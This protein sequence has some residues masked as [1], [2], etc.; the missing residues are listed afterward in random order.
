[1]VPLYSIG[2]ILAHLIVEVS[3]RYKYSVI[4]MLIILASFALYAPKL[5]IFD[6]KVK[7]LS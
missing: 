4:P 7:T 6:K 2:L 1:M 3:G 5:K